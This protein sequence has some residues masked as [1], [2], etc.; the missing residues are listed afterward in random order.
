MINFNDLIKSCKYL[1]NSY[2]LNEYKNYLNNRISLDMQ[3]KFD[4]G[5]F[6]SKDN[7]C[8][9]TQL[10]DKQ[11]LING[12]LIYEINHLNKKM[13]YSYFEDHNIV[14]PYKDTYG[15]CIGLIGRT[16]KDDKSLIKYKNT[17]FKK[18]LHLFGLYEGKQ[19]IL[20]KDCCF[21]VEGQ[22][23]VI[24]SHQNNL[25]N[26]VGLGSGSMSFYQF[27]LLLRYTKNINLLLDNDEAGEK[28]RKKIMNSFRFICKY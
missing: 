16:I 27:G 1:Y 2:D 12:K 10:F 28:A 8:L 25:E 20:E 6:P 18:S 14:I 17:V 4:I 19:S 5:Y 13:Y 9:I 15:N 21:V 23:D 24:S 7:I 11:E 26:I 22:I 3:D